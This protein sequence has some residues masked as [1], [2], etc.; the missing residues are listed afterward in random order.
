[1]RKDI[2]MQITFKA[3]SEEQRNYLEH[4]IGHSN[5]CDAGMVNGMCIK[6]GEGCISQLEEDIKEVTGEDV[7]IKKNYY[8]NCVC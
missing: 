2:I 5:C 1:M 4:A 6:C 7:S 8:N 3:L